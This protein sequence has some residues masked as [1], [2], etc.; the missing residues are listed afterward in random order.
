MCGQDQGRRQPGAQIYLLRLEPL[1]SCSHL[2]YVRPLPRVHFPTYFVTPTLQVFD[3]LDEDKNGVIDHHELKK[4]LQSLGQV[5]Q[6]LVS[7]P[8][9]EAPICSP[10]TSHSPNDAY[11]KYHLF[12][13]RC[14]N[15][16]VAIPH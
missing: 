7:K 11:H 4:L 2:P 14:V 5:S 9:H 13:P 1:T 6:G 15:D 10:H 12:E 3:E 16:H 8:L